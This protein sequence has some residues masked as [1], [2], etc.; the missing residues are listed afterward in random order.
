M[1]KATSLHDLMAATLLS[2]GGLANPFT[3]DI[4]AAGY[5]INN[6]AAPID[7]DDAATKGFIEGLLAGLHDGTDGY[8][9]NAQAANTASTANHA[10]NADY[11]FNG[12][13]YTATTDF[14]NGGSG[15]VNY[16]NEAGLA[17]NAD[18]ASTAGAA[19][20]ADT[21]WNGYSYVGSQGLFDGTDGNVAFAVSA[22]YADNAT[23]IQNDMSGYTA[24]SGLFDGSVGNVA[25][26]GVSYGLVTDNSGAPPSN[27][28][29]TPGQMFF[30]DTHIYRCFAN[31]D[32]RRVAVAY[33][34]Y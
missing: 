26:A 14:F 10:Y 4:D 19:S 30:D 20:Q 27:G 21:I 18:Y 12:S 28:G 16:A 34:T 29:G 23:A 25:F 2:A 7:A 17:H 15:Y 31:G 11:I 22:T 5:R 33:A 3:F 32:W 13:D 24:T 9:A 8:V 1:S 6:L